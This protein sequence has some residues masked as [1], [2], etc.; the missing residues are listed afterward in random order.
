M[1]KANSPDPAKYLPEL[2]KID[3]KGA[4]GQ[5]GFDEKGDRR[6]AEMTIFTMKGGKIEPVAVIK[7]GKTIPIADFIAAM[8]PPAPAAAPA[9]AAPAPA[10]AA[11]TPAPAP[12]APSEPAKK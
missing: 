7:D 9:A 8:A 2:T 4:T 3:Y 5:I 11:P 1:K 10:D 12:A 6:N